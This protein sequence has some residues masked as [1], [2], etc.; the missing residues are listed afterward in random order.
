M[1]GG[2]YVIQMRSAFEQLTWACIENIIIEKFG[3][4]A[5]RIFRVVRLKKFI[6]QED[7]Q[8]E[9]MMPSKEAKMLTYKLLEEHFLQVIYFF[10]L[11]SKSSFK[12][13]I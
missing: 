10:L 12:K 3:S 7:I 5:A 8:K 6:E 1:G 11:F 4:K 2:Q 9:A 13:F